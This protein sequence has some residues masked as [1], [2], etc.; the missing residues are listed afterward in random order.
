MP[1][2]VAVP[3]IAFRVSLRV[4][5]MSGMTNIAGQTRD[6]STSLTCPKCKSPMEKVTFRRRSRWTGV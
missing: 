1:R 6:E 2:A 5:S 3:A 4:D